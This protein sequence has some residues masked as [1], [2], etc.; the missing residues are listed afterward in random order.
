VHINCPTISYTNRYRQLKKHKMKN[1]FVILTI[2]LFI[3]ISAKSQISYENRIEIDLK[4]GYGNEEIFEFGKHGF[5]MSSKNQEVTG[6][7]TEYKFEKYNTELKLVQTR[8]IL[9]DKKFRVDETFT[10]DK[11]L[12]SLFKDRK[13][14]FSIVT[15]ESSDLKLTQVNGVL[16]KKAWIK[17]M[18]ILGDYAFFSASIKRSPFLYSVNWKTGEK[19]LIPI[20]VGNIN[21]KKISIINFQVLESSN[22][23]FVYVKAIIDKS[24]SDIYV[25]RLNNKGSKVDAFNLTEN[26]EENIIDVSA[27]RL[28][29][30]K[31]IYTGTYSTKYTSSS[32]GLF[33]CQTE[34]NKINFI[35]FYSFLDLENFLS[36]LP[37]KRQEKIEKKK[38]KKEKKGKELKFNYRI[39]PHEIISLDDGYLFLGEAYYATYRSETYTTTSTVNGVTTTTTQTRQVFDGYQYT[40]A[41]LGKFDKKGK[42]L[43]DETFEMWSAYKPFYV[44]Q[45]IS[46]AE[47]GQ[48]SIKLVFA[49]RNKIISKSIDFSGSVLQDIQSEEIQTNFERDKVKR[50]F[51]NINHW[52]EN[53]FIAYGNQKIK[54]I[55]DKRKRKVY[56]INK[57]KFEN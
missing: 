1:I 4:D 55:D 57:I 45:F 18:S 33:F 19:S 38:E 44:K 49:S 17:D 29:E 5:V 54:N 32:E 13:G 16:P 7:K 12:H 28:D 39:S 56:F 48:N 3:S 25:I 43:W 27:L 30:D 22:E 42:L 50:S 46:I 26:V 34:E 37:E 14:N 11:R 24:K 21:P 31:Y 40:H 10:N 36:Y 15:F 23:I 51:S 41:V 2:N 20:L 6:N 47:K 52:Y 8:N 53:Y 35:E 9:L